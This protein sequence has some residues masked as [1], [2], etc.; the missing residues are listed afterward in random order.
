MGFD[1]SAI[2]QMLDQAVASG[3]FH[4][5]AAMVVD[6]DGVMYEHAAG[7]SSAGTIYRN[8][9]MT[10]AVATT[11]ALQLLEQGRLRLDATVESVLPEFGE[12]QVIDGF[13][14]EG[15]PLLRAPAGK[16]SIR[17]LMN[18]TSG[19]GYF[20]LNE[21]L[22]RLGSLTGMP[23]PIEG[24]KVALNAP[25]V[26]DPGT[27]WEYGVSTDWLG[28]VVEQ[29]VGQRL[30]EYVAEHIYRPL[31]MV[32]S[33]F[34]FDSVPRDRLL[35]IRLRAADGTLQPTEID[36][37]T[38]AEWDAGG[39]GSLGTIQDYARFIRAWLR[40][41]ELDGAR[42][43]SPETVALAFE[44]HLA[45]ATLPEVMRS[46]VPELAN[47]VPALPVP[48]G[49]GLG[50]HLVSVDIPG[51]RSAGTGDWA[52]LFNSYYWIDRAA[53]LG[54]VIMTQI[55]PFFDAQVVETLIGFEVAAYA[56]LA[57]LTA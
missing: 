4:G 37:P 40:D 26:N 32:D 53:G 44:D 36:L 12:L 2:D 45:G 31:G 28:L 50:F 46:L 10:K 54:G 21:K 7:E 3:V 41:G 30:G 13:D 49:W 42:I 29:I 14:G 8:A 34:N 5:V 27:V 11:A 57:A 22:L 19:L 23:S 15:Q 9:S 33:T 48:Q 43:L 35:P 18:H 51:M 52:G 16:P 39:H 56:Q 24:K 47:D 1:G 6:R 25:L 55:L 38:G 20:F 17:Q